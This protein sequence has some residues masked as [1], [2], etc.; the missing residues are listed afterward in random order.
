ML[1]GGKN[2]I[3]LVSIPVDWEEPVKMENEKEES[4]LSEMRKKLRECKL[5]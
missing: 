2:R 1:G 3:N 5:I 4:E